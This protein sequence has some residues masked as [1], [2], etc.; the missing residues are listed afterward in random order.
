MSSKNIF[1]FRNIARFY[2][3]LFAEGILWTVLLESKYNSN[4][5]PK[6]TV[7]FRQNKQDSDV[8]LVDLF[9][10]I[11]REIIVLFFIFPNLTSLFFL[12]ILGKG[13]YAP[14]RQTGL[15]SDCSNE[16]DNF[17]Y[18]PNG[19][20]SPDKITTIISWQNFQSQE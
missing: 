3:S 5:R 1:V 7:P 19:V 14:T 11:K 10:I 2:L 17:K 16:T 6:L 12:L 4:F 20:I 18:K 13:N 9:L 15:L 8:H